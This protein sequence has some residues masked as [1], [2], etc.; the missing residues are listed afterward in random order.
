MSAGTATIEKAVPE[1]LDA[2]VALENRCFETDRLSRR[3]FRRWL[4]ARHCA[5]FVARVDARLAGYCLIIFLR[6][7]TLARLYSIAVDPDFRGLGIARQLID[8]GERAAVDDGRLFLRLEVGVDNEAGINLYRSL[9]YQPFGV[10]H[11]YYEDDNDALRMQKCVR[12]YTGAEANRSIPWIRQTTTFSCGPAAL[13]MAMGGVDPVR[14]PTLHEELQIWREATT[15]FMTSGH[16]GCHPVGLA[17]AGRRRGYD[18]EVWLN[19]PGTL[20]LDGVR[21]ENKKRVVELVHMDYIDQARQQDLP[22][23]YREFSDRDLAEAFDRGQVPVILIST[24][25]LDG[26][27]A[28]HWV[29]MS[30]YDEDCLYVHDPDPD[31]EEQSASGIDSQYLPIARR[32]FTAMSRFGRSQL[33]T[34]VLVKGRIPQ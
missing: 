22:L 33:R 5:F 25:R 18:V 19:Q 32:D 34:A 29:T 1:D 16:G 3:S 12:R 9:G 30:G 20:F 10:Y 24:Y 23:L 2:L 8:E 31:P 28:P 15:I 11:Q 13:M 4:G 7:T 26:K 27:K 21:S 14:I 6:G 17:L